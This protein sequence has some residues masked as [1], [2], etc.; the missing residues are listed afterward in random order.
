MN[1]SDS[2]KTTVTAWI[3]DGKTLAE[4]QRMLR[5]EFSLSMTYMDVRFL[6]DDLE[7]T[8]AEPE[9]EETAQDA[10]VEAIEP[11]VMDAPGEVSVEV[12]AIV[13]PGAL[14]SGTVKFT[15]G[16]SLGWQLASSGQL[17]LIPGDD[18]NYRPD[19]EDIQVF[20]TKL[21]DVLREKGL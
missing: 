20:Q 8:F 4:V 14:V 18:P 7:I 17:G 11:E 21:E 15:D 10:E 2:Q 16:V 3:Q 12:D 1:L 6:I 5:E 19:P 9:A 13:R